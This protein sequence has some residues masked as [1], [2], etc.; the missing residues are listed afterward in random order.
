MF[1]WNGLLDVLEDDPDIVSVLA[2]ELF[3]TLPTAISTQET[4]AGEM[5][6]FDP[7]AV[8]FS[9]VNAV[10]TLHDRVKALRSRV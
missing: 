8:V 6:Y 1:K 4:Q 3:S 7:T 2:Q 9:L 5:A 10:K